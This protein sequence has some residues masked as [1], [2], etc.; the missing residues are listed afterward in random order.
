MNEANG[1][2]LTFCLYSIAHTFCLD[3]RFATATVIGLGVVL[4]AVFGQ[5]IVDLRPA[6]KIHEC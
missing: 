6:G 4:K 5:L 2:C 3:L 1:C